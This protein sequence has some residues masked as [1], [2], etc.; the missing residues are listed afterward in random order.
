MPVLAH[1]TERCFPVSS[2]AVD[3]DLAD[4]L[5]GC[6]VS[7]SVSEAR[8]LVELLGRD[9]TLC[10]LHL[11]NAEWSEH[12]S[13]KSSR[14]TLRLLPTS[15][16]TVIQGPQED[17]GILLLCD[18]GDGDRWGIVIAHESHNHPS[19]VLPVEGAA[20]GI[21]GIVRD[22]DCMGAHVVAVADPLRFGSLDGPHADRTRWIA[23]GVVDGIWQYGNPLGVPNLAGDVVFDRCYDDN[24]LVNVVALGLVRESRIIHS[25]V[26]AEAAD[27][28]YDLILIGKPTDDSGFGGAAFASVT[29]DEAD[30]RS[31]RGAV[32]VPDPFLKN[33]LLMHKANEAVREA[34]WAAGAAVGMKDLGAAGIGCSSSELCAAGGF[35]A[36]ID[37]D[38]CPQ[39]LPDLLPEVVTVAETQERYLW[40]VPRWFSPTVLRIYNDEWELPTVYEGARAAVIGEATL[41]RRYVLLH[42]DQIVCDADIDD[43]TAGVLYERAERP[44]AAGDAEPDSAPIADLGEVL[45]R[46]LASPNLASREMIF[47]YYDTEVQ[48]QAVLR[49]GEADAGVIAPLP[50][51]PVG[52]ALSVDGTPRYGAVDPY[53]GARAAVAEAMRNV[54]AVGATPVGMTDCL[55]FGNPEVPEAFWEFRESVK[56]LADAARELWLR[57]YPG[58]PCPYVSG[59]VSFYNQSAAGRAVYPSPIVACL[60]VIDDHSRCV[61]LQL[62]QPGNLL[63]LA[64]ARRDELG[65]SVYY[66][67]VLDRLGA[68]LPRVDGEHER[69]LIHGAIDAVA[70]GAVAAC[71]DISNGGLLVSLAEMAMG[72]WGAGTCGA[73]LDAAAVPFA[74]EVPEARRRA[75]LW[76]GETGGFVCEVVPARASEVVNLFAARGVAAAVVGKVTA[77]PRLTVIEGGATSLDLPLERL[78][79]AWLGGL[80]EALR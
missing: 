38:A 62:K 21:G 37:L 70:T 3:H 58:E 17:A 55:N 63:V 61:T 18:A 14:T 11:F 54:A 59:N 49:P 34:A 9:P 77:A 47:R 36:R 40:A 75:A 12:C 72:G 26:P 7:L 69:N 25:R 27:E 13:Y 76:F 78:K 57:D 16:P 79:A 56:G 66:D 64:G 29:L 46:L 28:P 5:A 4:A 23:G 42:H 24:C 32:Q 43:V 65:G 6:G 19:Q 33:V 73:E 2:H 44:R 20:T 80:P 1:L 35:G 60:G 50:D 53:H 67:V 8:R 45:L 15:G 52:A 74:G 39:A 10:E 68:N 30:E 71:H 41:E 51:R 48:G 31:N 22:V